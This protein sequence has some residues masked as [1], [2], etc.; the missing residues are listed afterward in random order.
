MPSDLFDPVRQRRAFE[1]I[2]LQVEQAIM[3]GRLSPGDRLPPE[4]E[5]AQIFWDAHGIEQRGLG[6]HCWLTQKGHKQADLARLQLRAKAGRLAITA[7][8][9]HM[10]TRAADDFVP[11]CAALGRNLPR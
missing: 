8:P 3:D 2:V 5:L 11:R 9:R 4:R 10:K 1:E 6:R 7:A